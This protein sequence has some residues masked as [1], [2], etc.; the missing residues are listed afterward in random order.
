[1]GAWRAPQLLTRL[2]R[3]LATALPIAAGGALILFGLRRPT[4]PN[5]APPPAIQRQE[6]RIPSARGSLRAHSWLAGYEQMVRVGLATPVPT[7]VNLGLPAALLDPSVPVQEEAVRLAA[8]AE[9]PLPIPSPTPAR[10]GITVYQVQAGDNLWVIAQRF[11][12][13]QDTVVWANP[14]LEQHPDQL[15]IGQELQILPIDGV[16]H[17]VKAGETLSGIAGRYHVDMKD[18]INYAPNGISD[19]GSLT[20]GQKLIIPGG[21]RPSEPTPVPTTL[22][23]APAQPAP[24]V[25]VGLG[26]AGAP[27]INGMLA[28]PAGAPGTPVAAPAQP[29]RFVWPARGTITQYYGKWH[30]A[31][32]IANKPGTPI[33]AAD[34]G[35]VAFAAP[36]GG[37]GN[38]IYID[39]GD[40]FATAY[41]HLAT[42]AVQPGQKVEKGQQIGTMGSTGRST[43]PHLHLIFTY[44]GG[45]IDPLQYL[46]G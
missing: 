32:D 29:G 5:S 36:S 23:K 10:A 2:H 43:G 30:G 9:P 35:I 45:I 28:I 31:I 11:H 34:A 7:A 6:G 19:P 25:P 41:A 17:T 37:L 27:T 20:I 16:L 12:L 22:P 26:V 42:I 1:M 44:Q 38:A 8:S 4:A 24:S 13:S 40:G 3:V 39:H 15:S 18:I 46:P 21:T 14:G 33:I